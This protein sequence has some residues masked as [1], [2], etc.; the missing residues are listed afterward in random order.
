MSAKERKNR[1]KRLLAALLSATVMLV[2]CG[3]GG[4]KQKRTTGVV[5][6]PE[7]LG[8]QV[9]FAYNDPKDDDKG[10]GKYQYPLKFNNREGYCDITKF[11][12][13]DGGANVI[14]TI[15]CR[16][17]IPRRRDDGTTEPKGWWLQMMDIYIDKDNRNGSGYTRALPGRHVTFEKESAWEKV[18]LITPNHSRTVQKM[19]EER[20]SDMDLVHMRKKIVIPHRAYAQG[21]TFVAYVPKFE[22]GTPQ[23]NWGYQVLMTGYREENLA[24]GQFQNE[25]VIKFAGQEQF[26]GGSDYRGDPNVIDMLA[27]TAA[28]QYAILSNHISAPYSGDD[29]WA[30]IKCIYGGEAAAV[31]PPEQQTVISPGV[32]VE[33]PADKYLAEQSEWQKPASKEQTPPYVP[34]VVSRPAAVPHEALTPPVAPTT[35]PVKQE[36]SKVDNRAVHSFEGGF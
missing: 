35:K 16:R 25:E 23:P 7:S 19:L 17:P 27:P 18:V 31:T 3:G 10:P 6:T 21:Y 9:Y 12:V 24:M 36:K 33:T 29:R 13:E 20:T 14:F 2:G 26:G 28:E 34:S 30:K 11:T 8:R 4:S 5:H 15:T 32:K 22:I 1:K